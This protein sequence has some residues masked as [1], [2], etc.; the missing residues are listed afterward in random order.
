M[1]AYA[2]DTPFPKYISSSLDGFKRRVD[3]MS[4]MFEGYIEP[5]EVAKRSQMTYVSMIINRIGLELDGL[6]V[7][8]LS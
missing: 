3:Q 8:N 4:E 1:W 5:K 2:Q 6:I 7:R